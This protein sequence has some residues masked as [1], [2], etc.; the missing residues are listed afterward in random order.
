M[1][2]IDYRVDPYTLCLYLGVHGT[3]TM[4]A[5]PATATAYVYK[6]TNRNYENEAIV[7]FRQDFLVTHTCTNR[8]LMRNH[9]P[10]MSIYKKFTLLHQVN[11]VVC[12]LQAIV[13]NRF[14][15]REKHA[16]IQ[17]CFKGRFFL[18]FSII[19][20]KTPQNCRSIAVLLFNVVSRSCVC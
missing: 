13:S 8:N 19:S 11:F 16:K 18:Q 12:K 14:L 1:K 10:Q 4:L 9:H 7:D 20:S 17:N 6:D 5:L 15:E 3:S 2:G